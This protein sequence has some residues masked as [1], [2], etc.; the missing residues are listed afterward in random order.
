VPVEDRGG[1]NPE[2][3]VERL[4]VHWV[5]VAAV[6]LLGLALVRVLRHRD[7]AP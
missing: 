5:T 7:A 3:P 1:Y 6:I 2:Y 4:P